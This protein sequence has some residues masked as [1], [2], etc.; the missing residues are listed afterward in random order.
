MTYPLV[1]ELKTDGI[2]IER[3]CRVLG[4]SPQAFYKWQASP[5]SD[6]DW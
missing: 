1:I 6:R 4:F 5:N 3:S 2:P